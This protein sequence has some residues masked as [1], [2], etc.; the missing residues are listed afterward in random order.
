MPRGFN[1]WV[2]ATVG[3]DLGSGV[4]AFSLAWVASGHG[5]ALVSAVLTLTVA[6]SVL[7]GLLG[8]AVADRFGPRRVMIVCTCAFM[9]ISAVLA[10]TVTVRPMSPVALVVAAA[11]IGTVSAFHRPAV[12]VFPRMFVVDAELGAAMAR[13]GMASQVAG[14]IAPPLGGILVGVIALSG[15]AW[16]DVVGC[17]CMVMVLLAVRPPI[18]SSPAMEAVSVRGI[19]RGIATAG[20]TRGAP[21]LLAC[22]ALVAGA[23][24]PSMV[25]GIPLVARE[26]GW[27]AAEA[28]LIEAGWIAGGLLA[29]AW[30]SWRG[31]SARAWRGIAIGPVLVACGLAA[32]AVSPS[33]T[34]AAGGTGI[35]GFGVVIFT[36]HVFPTYVRLAP[37]SMLSRFQSVLILAQRAP[38]LVVTPLIG[39]LIGFTT[40]GPAFLCGAVVA[41]VATVVVAANKT[42]RAVGSASVAGGVSPA[43]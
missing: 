5:P 36:A 25:V 33:W 34:S 6:P 20:E 40:T 13:V 2:V 41:L 11:A 4:L 14:A 7:F 16:I 39:I 29:G 42:L 23:V 19:L 27:T 8:G 3:A 32:L 28:G 1:A 37:A 35:I 15:V 31:T 9:S 12:G 17:I 24:I 18:A 21:A 22:V 38:Q 43:P 26:R 10:L 30:F